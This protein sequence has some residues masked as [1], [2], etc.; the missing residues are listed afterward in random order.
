MRTR[1]LEQER[2]RELLET[3]LQLASVKVD[4]L[5][6]ERLGFEERLLQ[7]TQQKESFANELTSVK[8][9]LKEVEQNTLREVRL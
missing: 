2:A 6:S 1:L 8:A 3:E 7:E 5:Q 9:L 4:K